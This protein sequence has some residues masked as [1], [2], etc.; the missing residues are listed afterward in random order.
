[1]GKEKPEKIII[2]SLV[3]TCESFPSQW[4]AL[5]ING[6]YIYIRYRWGKLTVERCD[7]KESYD[8]FNVKSEMLLSKQ[9]GDLLDGELNT[10]DLIE[11]L[12]AEGLI[13]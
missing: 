13:K 6:K 7:T 12:K 10:D 9:L 11:I 2:E 3:M 8:Y 4:D 5:D 1:M